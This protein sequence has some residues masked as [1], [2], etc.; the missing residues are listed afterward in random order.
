MIGVKQTVKT[1][2]PSQ[3]TSLILYFDTLSTFQQADCPPAEPTDEGNHIHNSMLSLTKHLLGEY[4]CQPNENLFDLIL[5][6]ADKQQTFKL[7]HFLM[8]SGIS[9]LSGVT[10]SNALNT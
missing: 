6:F 5:L 9:F 7:V 10:C 2:M 3:V 1:V 4:F 8:K